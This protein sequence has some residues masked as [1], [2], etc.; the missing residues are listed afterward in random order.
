[1]KRIGSKEAA[2][3]LGICK[4]ELQVMRKNRRI[5]F[6]RISHRTITYDIADLDKFLESVHVPAA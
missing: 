1:M 3:Y 6:Y 5:P 2:L 4:R